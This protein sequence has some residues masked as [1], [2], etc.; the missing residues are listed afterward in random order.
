MELSSIELAVRV[1]VWDWGPDRS[2][3]GANALVTAAGWIIH[4][5]WTRVTTILIT[6]ISR[7]RFPAFNQNGGK[8]ETVGNSSTDCTF[9]L[10]TKSG[11]AF[12]IRIPIKWLFLCRYIIF[13]LWTRKI[14]NFYIFWN[15][16]KTL[17][18][19][20]YIYF[21]TLKKIKHKSIV[22]ISANIFFYF[23]CSLH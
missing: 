4:T 1:R 13:F 2:S 7:R 10:A 15:V 9:Q 18:Y 8:H 3:I 12:W 6:S 23:P 14:K 16:L 21:M 19:I 5:F 22:L 17:Y 20:K 11:C